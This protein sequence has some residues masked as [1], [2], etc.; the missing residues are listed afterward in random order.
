[1][2]HGI[3]M[4][5]RGRKKNFMWPSIARLRDGRLIAVSSGFRMKHVCPFGKV[6][7]S[8]SKDDGKS[9]S[10]PFVLFDTPL[11]DR[12]AGV[13]PFRGGFVLTTFNNTRLFQKKCEEK[14]EYPPSERKLIDEYLATVSDADEG[15][16]FGSL[17]AVFDGDC[18]LQHWGKLPVT[19]PHGFTQTRGGKLLYVG[20]NF[21]HEDVTGAECDE[22][23]RIGCISTGD[24]VSFSDPVWI[25]LPEKEKEDGVLFCEPHAL[26]LADGRILVHIRA[27]KEGLFSI[28]QCYSEDGG[29]SFSV[30]ERIPVGEEQFHGSPPHLLLTKSG[31]IVLTYGRRIAPFGQRARI[32]ED[33]GKSWSKEIILRSDG[34]GWDLGYPASAELCDGEILTVYYQRSEKTGGQAIWFTKWNIEEEL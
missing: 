34:D 12:D 20:R 16:Y 27:Q 2:E 25:P 4:S 26:E 14:W 24:C 19:S 23:N 10:K 15:K 11:D 32:S 33:G 9:W 22:E 6:A 18:N 29:K 13:T 17:Y 30:P 1:M 31:K 7:A 28:Y 3:V 8:I 21:Y 5:G